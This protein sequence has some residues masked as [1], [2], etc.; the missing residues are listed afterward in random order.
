[1]KLLGELGL[2]FDICVRP[3][4]LS[5]AVQLVA[6]CHQ[7]TAAVNRQIM[8]PRECRRHLK[9]PPFDLAARLPLAS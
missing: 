7:L 5:D 2:S 3:D 1:M 9:L 4:E 8:T 6:R